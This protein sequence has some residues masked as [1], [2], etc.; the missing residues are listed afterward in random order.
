[1]PS[2]PINQV[3]RGQAIRWNGEIYAIIG[4]DHVKP[5]KGPAY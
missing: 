3:N 4:M 1:M 5:G 2:I